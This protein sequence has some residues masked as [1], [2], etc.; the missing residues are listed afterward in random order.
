MP[1]G[2]REHI[3]DWIEEAVHERTRESRIQKTIEVTHARRERAR[4]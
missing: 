2:K 4:A 3:L 1:P